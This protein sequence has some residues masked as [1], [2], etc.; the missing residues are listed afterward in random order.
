MAKQKKTWS[1]LTVDQKRAIYVGG[2]AEAVLTIA[3]LRDLAKRPSVLVRGPKAAWVL[4]FF[5]QPFGPLTY[6]RF[7]RR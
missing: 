4:A 5:V 7:G 2:A 6:F 3:A 1:D